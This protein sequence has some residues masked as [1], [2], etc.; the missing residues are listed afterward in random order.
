[1]DVAIIGAAGSCGRQLAAQLLERAVLPAS[2]RLQLV[3][4]RG[5]RAEHEFWGL[6]ADLEDAF[7]DE[8]PAIELV[9]DPQG[10]DAS[11]VVMLAGATIPNDP[12]APTDRAALGRTNHRIF[13]EYADALADQ[14]RAAPTIIVQS[15][16][17]ELGV[18]VFAERLG[19][20]RVL[21]AG[22]WS[23][24]LRLRAEVAADL[25]VR[26]PRVHVP[27]LGQHGDNQVPIWS[28]LHVQGLEEARVADFAEAARA[29]RDLSA[30]PAEIRRERE[31][32]VASV[33]DGHVDAA[34][35]RIRALPPDLRAAVKPF[36][37]HFTS[38]HTTEMVTARAVADVVAALAA[39]EE[40]LL[41]AQVALE[42]EWLGIQGVIGAPVVLGPD[43]WTQVVTIALVDEEATAVRA[44][45][46]AIA[47]AAA[48]LAP[49]RQT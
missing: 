5:G 33:R 9:L 31:R 6:R 22:A 39:G 42:G 21:G 35:E 26:R 28:Q 20:H 32:M 18:Q 16:P 19:R 41:P 13:S 43:G 14:S 47:G 44:A 1:M 8:A 48:S 34:Y 10:I 49:G 37:T 3:G 2:A 17:V 23:D 4:H 15:N 27:V 45:A 38:G 40:R 30:L 36:F 24:T 7:E 12:G 29:G 11:L 46:D 25:G